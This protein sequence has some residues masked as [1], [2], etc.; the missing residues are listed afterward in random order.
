[1]SAGPTSWADLYPYRPPTCRAMATPWP[2][3]SKTPLEMSL[4]CRCPRGQA[5]LRTKNGQS[6]DLM[7]VHYRWPTALFNHQSGKLPGDRRTAA[8]DDIVAGDMN[9]TPWSFTLRRQDKAF[10]LQRRTRAFWSWPARTPSGGPFPFPFLPIDQVYAGSDWRT[11]SVERGPRQGSDH[12]PVIVTLAYQGDATGDEPMNIEGSVG[13][14]TGANRGPGQGLCAGPARRRRGQVY[15]GSADPSAITD[16]RLV[17]IKLDVTSTSRI[18]P[19]QRGLFDVTL[20]I[21]NAGAM[22]LSPMLAPGSDESYLRREMEVNVFGMQAMIRAFRPILAANGGGAIINMLSGGEL[23]RR[24]LSIYRH[25][26][27]PP[28]RQRRLPAS[29]SRRRAR[30]LSGVYAG[31]IDTDMAAASAVRDLAATGG[32]RSLDGV[33]RGRNHRARRQTA[34]R[35]SGTICALTRRLR[36]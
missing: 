22:L 19:P 14:V 1:M 20:L 25:R 34:P 10:G 11:V 7:A 32:E 21:N 18:S 8:Q 33:A 36:R 17:P 4:A 23:V 27:R 26:S 16:P 9:L 29:N 31:F 15:A 28:W 5:K 35:K 6:F 13:L 12:Y 3:L 2:I 24:A 30:R